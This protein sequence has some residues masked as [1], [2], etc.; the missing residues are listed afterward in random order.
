MK[1]W[2]RSSKTA[3]A[4]SGDGRVFE[5]VEDLVIDPLLRELRD[6]P[7]NDVVGGFHERPG[8]TQGLD[9]NGQLA[10]IRQGVTRHG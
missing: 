10:V 5:V 7:G 1:K 3:S 2:T 6:A 4:G 8:D 9:E